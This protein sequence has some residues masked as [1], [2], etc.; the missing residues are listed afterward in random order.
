VLQFHR[1]NSPQILVKSSCYGKKTLVI[2]RKI[3]R[4]Q[5]LDFIIRRNDQIEHIKYQ[6]RS[7]NHFY[8][9]SYYS[10]LV[11]GSLSLLE[12]FSSV[13]CGGC[14]NCFSKPSGLGWLFP[15]PYPSY[16]IS[17]FSLGVLGSL[18]SPRV[19]NWKDA[20]LRHR[21]ED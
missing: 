2:S 12:H 14:G 10:P 11:F 17:S 5:K 9:C 3:T 13:D 7:K 21:G 18:G 15:S 19:S 8:L 16:C 4:N 1:K 6:T 20:P